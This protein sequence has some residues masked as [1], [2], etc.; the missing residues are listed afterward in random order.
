MADQMMHVLVSTV[1]SLPLNSQLPCG[2][3]CTRPPTGNW[4][5]CYCYVNRCNDRDPS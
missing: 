1:Q 4:T 3:E 5:D 2:G